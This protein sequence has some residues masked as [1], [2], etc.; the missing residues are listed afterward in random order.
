MHAVVSMRDHEPW[1]VRTF[2]SEADAYSWASSHIH[3]TDEEAYNEIIGET[4][5]GLVDGKHVV[6][7]YNLEYLEPGEHFYVLEVM[8]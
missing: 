3:E 5:P 4:L 2:A 7:T 8:T 1:F 6:E